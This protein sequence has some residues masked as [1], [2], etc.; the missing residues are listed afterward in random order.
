[1]KLHTCP[2]MTSRRVRGN[3]TYAFCVCGSHNRAVSSHDYLRTTGVMR[4]GEPRIGKQ[5]WPNLCQSD[6]NDRTHLI[7][8]NSFWSRDFNFG[9]RI[10]R[11]SPIR[12]DTLCPH[13][14]HIDAPSTDFASP[15]LCGEMTL[16]SSIS[17]KE[18]K[19]EKKMAFF[20]GDQN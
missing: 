5:P 10:R 2:L 1:M 12:Y 6:V 7:Q 15:A 13:A 16:Q 9:P 19:K 11:T 18:R 20:C 17:L 14:S 4:I 8:C 3:L